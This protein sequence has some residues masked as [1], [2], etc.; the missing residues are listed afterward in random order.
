MKNRILIST[1]AAITASLT[2]CG[3]QVPQAP[4]DSGIVIYQNTSAETDTAPQ[5]LIT[6]S[7]P[8]EI[9]DEEVDIDLTHLGATMVYSQIYDMVVNGDAY[10]GKTVKANGQF[11]YFQEADGREFY[12]VLISDATAFCSQG[13]E[14]VLDGEYSYPD[15]YPAIG[16][17]ITVVGTFNYY[18]EDIYTYIQLT[19]ARMITEET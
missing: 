16:T 19:D 2:G 5:E 15:D 14:F 1:L 8:Q 13:L 11:A 3:S 4:S 6:V 7:E 12:S 10:V 18:M 9:V 17:D